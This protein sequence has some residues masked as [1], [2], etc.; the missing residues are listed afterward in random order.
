MATLSLCAGLDPGIPALDRSAST[1]DIWGCQDLGE[2]GGS[3]WV[4]AR[5]PAGHPMAENYPTPT[6]SSS[7]VEKASLSP[8]M[9][10]HPNECC[11]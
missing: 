7:V 3:L 1:R 4:E 8:A 10:H 2:V 5:E 6:I 9:R 11:P